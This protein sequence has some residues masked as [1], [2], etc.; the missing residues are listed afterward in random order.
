MFIKCFSL[1]GL[2]GDISYKETDTEFDHYLSTGVLGNYRN[3]P[4][5]TGGYPSG[6]PNVEFQNKTEIFNTDW[7]FNYFLVFLTL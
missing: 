3:F 1:Y 4:F 7:V 6:G 5:V 2:N